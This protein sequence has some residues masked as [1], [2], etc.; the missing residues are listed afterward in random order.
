LS[1]PVRVIWS[2]ARGDLLNWRYDAPVHRL[3]V[4]G[5]GDLSHR[6]TGH[7]VVIEAP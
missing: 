2:N 7:A 6:H 5:A 4:A 1:V 3:H